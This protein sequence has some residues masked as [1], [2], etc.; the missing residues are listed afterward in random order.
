[1]IIRGA[2]KG[3]SG[4]G[5]KKCDCLYITDDQS[6]LLKNAA[7]GCKSYKLELLQDPSGKVQTRCQWAET[8]GNAIFCTDTR[9]P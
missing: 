7:V 9:N 1:M 5:R 4:S 2:G 8:E 3:K 6:L